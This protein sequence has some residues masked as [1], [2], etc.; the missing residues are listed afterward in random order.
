VSQYLK[1][2]RVS[3]SESLLVRLDPVCPFLDDDRMSDEDDI[4]ALSLCGCLHSDKLT[5]R[6]VVDVLCPDWPVDLLNFF[7]FLVFVNKSV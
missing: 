7:P 6:C 2:C 3:A 5:K 1:E 4:F